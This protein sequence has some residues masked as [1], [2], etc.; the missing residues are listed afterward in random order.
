MRRVM[1]PPRPRPP[2]VRRLRWPLWAFAALLLLRAAMPMLATASAGL[3][4]RDLV[5]VCS[6]YGAKLVSLDGGAEHR[7]APSDPMADHGGDHCAL[8]ALA[9][10]A[11]P[12]V[13]LP[14]ALPTSPGRAPPG[15][16]ASSRAG[17]D[18]C[19]RWVARLKHGPPEVA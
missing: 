10:L 13:P 19:A 4:G 6:V 5:E 12:P 2:T 17:L 14:L 1:H 7:S 15:L 3:Q 9:A 11:H 18:A 8:N 16:S